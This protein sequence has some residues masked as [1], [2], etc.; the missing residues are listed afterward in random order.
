M[1]HVCNLI[2][3]NQNDFNNALKTIDADRIIS[4]NKSGYSES[5]QWEIVY[6]CDGGKHEK[7]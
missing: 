6:R 2:F 3:N 1:Q 4:I 7:K 5:S